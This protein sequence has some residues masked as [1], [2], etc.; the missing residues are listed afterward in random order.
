VKV[1]H[2]IDHMGPGGEQVVVLN[3]VET[4]GRQIQ[5]EVWSL[6]A[7]SLP[8]AGERLRAA[9]TPFRTLA[10]SKLD[11]R[12]PFRLRAELARA[13]ADLVHLHLELSGS[14]G[15]AAALSLGPARPL[16]V[17][18]VSNDPIGRY[19][20][21]HRIAGRL[22]A[23]RLDAHVAI[24]SSIARSIQAAYAGRARR[25][26]VIPPGLDLGRFEAPSIDPARV[27]ALRGAA[28]RVVGGVGRLGEQKAFHVLL[29]AVP[30]LLA[31]EPRTRVL[32]VGEGPLRGALEARARRLGVDK[33]VSFTGYLSDP[34]PAF[35]AMDVFVLPSL[36]EGF[37]IVFLEAMA[38]GVPVVGT[39]VVG[40]VDAVEDG[41]TGLLVPPRD[42]AILAEAVLRLLSDAELATRLTTAASSRVRQRHSRELATWRTEAMYHELAEDRRKR[43]WPPLPEAATPETPGTRAAHALEARGANP[44][45]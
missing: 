23:P 39:R 20:W 17:A 40:S 35:R 4:R 29:D 33:A 1:L 24:S 27:A 8:S 44:H 38:M 16:L 15:A 18:S 2:V 45:V 11:P 6:G 34:L 7:R 28:V 10:L 42:P 9:E 14:F 32:I 3:T 5:A 30:R 21:P 13:R 37:G 36:D 19:S 26:E 41:V 25:V 43:R 31:A 22:L 12:A